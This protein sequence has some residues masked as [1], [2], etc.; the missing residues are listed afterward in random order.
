[1]GSS[2][3]KIAQE[4]F[5]R[6]KHPASDCTPPPVPNWQESC[7]IT[8]FLQTELIYRKP[9]QGN[10]YIRVLHGGWREKDV[11]VSFHPTIK[12]LSQKRNTAIKALPAGM[13]RSSPKSMLKGRNTPRE[14][15][16]LGE[17]RFGDREGLLCVGKH[18][19]TAKPRTFHVHKLQTC[20]IFLPLSKDPE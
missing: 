10:P 16:C 11:A 5:S 12:R 3:R 8:A 19:T 20:L 4:D 7:V 1:M 13:E 15:L 6:G 9:V 2:Y 14:T 18:Q 17:T